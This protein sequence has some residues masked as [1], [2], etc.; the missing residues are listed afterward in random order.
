MTPSR[1]DKP[2]LANGGSFA[3]VVP[4]PMRWAR[5]KTWAKRSRAGLLDGEFF[6]RM[7]TLER[8]NRG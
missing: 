3:A 8:Q 6:R 2:R 5:A 4:L 7:R 1:F